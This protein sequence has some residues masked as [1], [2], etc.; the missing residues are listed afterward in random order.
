MEVCSFRNFT[1]AV[2]HDELGNKGPDSPSI[3]GSN[4]LQMRGEHVLC[5]LQ[6]DLDSRSLTERVHIIETLA[7]FLDPNWSKIRNKRISFCL[8]LISRCHISLAYPDAELLVMG[9]SFC[10][11]M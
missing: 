11:F 8:P 4:G 6:N 2:E 7:N 3:L 9:E 1:E 5:I 10:P